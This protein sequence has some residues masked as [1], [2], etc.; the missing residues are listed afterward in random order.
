VLSPPV[1]FP[2]GGSFTTGRKSMKEKKR[3]CWIFPLICFLFFDACATTQFNSVWKDE[4][5]HGGP[6]KEILIIGVAKKSAT[7]SFQVSGRQE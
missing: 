1:I 2:A 6:L 5:Y 7:A 3:F 4:T